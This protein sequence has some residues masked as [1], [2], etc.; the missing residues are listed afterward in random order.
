M[1]K[2]SVIHL[3]ILLS[4]LA[5]KVF[6]QK[7]SLP[8]IGKTNEIG[9][10]IGSVLLI[11]LGGDPY[12]QPLGLTYKKT[13]RR[14][15]YKFSYNYYSNGTSPYATQKETE[16]LIMDS[17]KYDITKQS[18][19]RKH[20]FRVGAEY[21]LMFKN[22]LTMFLGADLLI[23]YAEMSSITNRTAF[24][25]DSI[26][27]SHN[28]ESNYYLSYLDNKI[29]NKNVDYMLNTGLA[30]NVGLIVPLTKRFQIACSHRTD[31]IL[32]NI[33]RVNKDYQTNQSN[34]FKYYRFDFDYGIPITEIALY[35]R[36]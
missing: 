29:K 14:L 1:R 33:N 6:S 19:N 10:N 3:A 24:K 18:K 13:N 9:I 8:S 12:S 21:R 25:I 16:Y 2:V 5:T 30:F 28:S 7:D 17:I 31:L 26:N 22:K 20:D 15:A 4:G 36:F 11:A 32:S 35:Y 34:K 27:V 23:G